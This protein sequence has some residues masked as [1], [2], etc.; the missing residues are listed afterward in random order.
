MKK[1]VVALT[2]LISAGAVLAEPPV[3]ALARN[4]GTLC[5]TR[6]YDSAWLKSH[7]GQTLK[8]VTLAIAENDDRDMFDMRLALDL[9]RGP[10]YGFGQCWWETNITGGPAEEG[11]E[12]SV[13]WRD[14]GRTIQ[15][16][17]AEAMATWTS[18]DT[19][20]TAKWHELNAADRIV[21]LNLV[22]RPECV[23]LIAKL[24]PNAASHS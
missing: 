5:F 11:A 17:L 8:G 22:G 16:R 4:D 21:R 18:Y 10:L 19:S 15:A 7:P 3:D 24:A 23:T 6:T 12:F 1:L 9:P 14:G 20:G 13:H 2:A